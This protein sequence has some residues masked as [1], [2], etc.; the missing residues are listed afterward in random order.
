MDSE[1]AKV[2]GLAVW[3]SLSAT[4]ILGVFFF[5]QMIVDRDRRGRFGLFAFVMMYLVALDLIRSFTG[6][7]PLV[8]EWLRLWWGGAYAGCALWMLGNS[9]RTSLGVSALLWLLGFACF[10][11]GNPSFATTLMFPLAWGATGAGFGRRY[12]AARGYASAV[13]CAYSIALATCCSL[14]F[15]IV[16]R[17]VMAAILFGYLHFAIVSVVSVLFGWIHLPR[18]LQGL[19]PVRTPPALATPFFAVVVVS[20]ILIDVALVRYQE[21]GPRVLIGGSL[22]QF[23]GTLALYLRHRHQLV[24]H[25]DNVSQLLEERTVELTRAREALSGQNDLLARKLAEQERDLK[26]KGDV[27]DRQRRLELAAQTA[28]QV[29]H[30]IQNLLSPVLGKVEEIE[31]AGSLQEAREQSSSIRRQIQQLLEV[32]TN[33]LALSRRGRPESRAVRLADLARDVAERFPG[34]PISL[35]TQ[36]EAW[37]LGSWAQM[38]RVLSNLVTNAVES[39][40]DRVVR[41]TIR[42]GLLDVERSRRC[43]LGFLGAGRHAFIEV[44]D[45]GPGIPAESLDKIFDPF[46]SSKG[47]RRHRSGTG[48]GL[49]IVAAVV[50]DHKGVVDLETGPTGTRFSLYFPPHEPSVGSPDLARLS[51]RATV[52]V[53]DD[54]KSVLQ[55]FG[56]LLKEVGWTVLVAESGADAIRAVQAQ[57]VDVILLDFNMPRMNGLE[58]FLGAMHLRPGVRA[59]VHS[60]YLTEEQAVKLRTLGVSTILLKP[61]GGLEVLKA[62]REAFDEKTSAKK[63]LSGLD[64]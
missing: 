11:W 54:D 7:D 57:E 51:C 33:L 55:S 56:P 58:T 9:N 45:A 37:I 26:A 16:A 61:A 43:H 29:A 47:G 27:I 21:W 35:E 28:G 52:L 30:D 17:G 32:N 60:S 2:S 63:R 39:D 6:I 64:G 44:A 41:V 4:L 10:R 3:G 22:V 50:D 53:V 18:E 36:G 19:S 20:E 15:S 48:L 59:V 46:F 23:V 42:T 14:Y 40:L 34:Q 38:V 25:T 1:L 5:V 31:D 24:I 13:L 49:T 12:A 8:Y 62:L